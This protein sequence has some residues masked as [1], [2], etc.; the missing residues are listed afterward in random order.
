MQMLYNSDSFTVVQFDL[1]PEDQPAGTPHRS[2]GYE[3]VD[4]F[5]RKDIFIDGA[6][7]QRFAIGAQ[8]L[9]ETSPSPEEFDDFIEGFTQ[10]A[11]HPL[12]AH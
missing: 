3:I 7:A 1:H 6:L 12:V 10:I 2:G 4:K 11:S 5:G 9:A 8:A